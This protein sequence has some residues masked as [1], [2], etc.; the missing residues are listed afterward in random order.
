MN[1]LGVSNYFLHNI[2]KAPT[3]KGISYKLCKVISLFFLFIF[4][5][6]SQV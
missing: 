3:E 2:V 5:N 6:D 1:T 4:V